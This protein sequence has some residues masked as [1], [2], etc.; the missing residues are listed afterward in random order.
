MGLTLKTDIQYLKGVG[1]KLG[2]LLRKRGIGTIEDL[3]EYYPRAYEDRRAARSISTLEEN[4]IVSLRAEIMRVSSIPM[5]KSRRRIY[6]VL[7][8]D[9]SGRIQCKYFRVPY[10]GFFERFQVGNQVRVIGK[11]IRYRGVLQFQHPDIRDVHSH[12]NE[13]DNKDIEGSR[14]CLVPLYT[15]VEGFNSVKVR[16]LLGVVLKQ[17]D[18]SKIEEDEDGAFDREGCLV[19]SDFLP[20]WI[21]DEYKLPLR[22]L[23]L[24]EIHQPSEEAGKLFHG[25]QSEFHRRIIFEEF[26]WLELF[27]ASR[28]SDFKRYEAPSMENEF[29]LVEEL[30]ESL[31]FE[32]TKAQERAFREIA[33][34]MLQPY[35]MHRLLQGDV[36]S[37]K[38]VVALM[39]ASFVKSSGYQ[40]SL[41]VPTEILADQHYQGAQK[42]LAPL[43]VRVAL[44]TG[45]MGSREKREVGEALRQG[46]IDLIIGTHALIQGDVE[47]YRLGLVIVDEQHRFGVAQRGQLKEKG[48]NPHFLVMTATPIPRTLAMTVYGDLDVSVMDGMP[49]GRIPIISRVAY[50]TKRPQVMQ[51]V[52]DQIKKGRQGYIIYP[53]VEESENIDLKNA[54]DEFEKL[55]RHFVNIRLGLLHGRM[56]TSEK[57]EVMNRFRH[58]DL[59]ILVSTTVVE[60][61]VDVPNA[62]IIIIEHVERFGLSQLHQLRGRVGRGEHRS[63]C[64]LMLGQSSSPEARERARIMENASDGFK[65]AEADLELRGPGEFLGTRQSGLDGFKMANLVRDV[66]ILQDARHAAFEVIRRDPKLDLPDH[67]ALK[68]QFMGQQGIVAMATT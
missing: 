44:L 55:Q 52:E 37:G 33:K 41:M 68:A 65:I 19:I 16:R 1:P 64:V 51:F 34:D 15:D 23:S 31:S 20:K 26:F 50:E 12:E 4:D 17:V 58:G 36:G 47:F 57:E 35:P 6:D 22:G 49:K 39:A 30:K 61:G 8:R 21:R 54:V 2:G 38:T 67:K 28:K 7:V 29:R 5:G 3:L 18:L 46:E 25:R 43:G 59:D 56:K 27:L 62:N 24:K 60:V 10:R 14:D 32:L 53:L 48:K 13:G 45:R 42:L 63:Y 40:T 11:I 9:Q 66:L